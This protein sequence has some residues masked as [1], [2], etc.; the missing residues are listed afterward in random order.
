VEGEFLSGCLRPHD[1]A[2]VG[3]I[4]EGAWE[5]AYAGRRHVESFVVYFTTLVALARTSRNLM[6]GPREIVFEFCGSKGDGLGARVQFGERRDVGPVR[7]QQRKRRLR[8]VYHE[9][10]A[11]LIGQSIVCPV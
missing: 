6:M 2:D 11:Y 8:L 7:V 10:L 4:V 5:N 3:G 1:E 9:R